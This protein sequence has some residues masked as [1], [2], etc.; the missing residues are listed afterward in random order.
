MV[1][2]ISQFD[3]EVVSFYTCLLKIWQFLSSA[4]GFLVILTLSRYKKSK[5]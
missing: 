3:F 4:T 5:N 2:M 1:S